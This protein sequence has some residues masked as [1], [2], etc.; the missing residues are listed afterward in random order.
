MYC[1]M[2]GCRTVFSW[3]TGRREYGAVHNPYALEYMR[4]HG[5]LG[6]DL[7]DIPCGGRPD[8]RELRA[9]IPEMKVRTE[10]S[11]FAHHC[12]MLMGHV[13]VEARRMTA[14][15][16]VVAENEQRS[17]ILFMRQRM[18]EDEYRR[19]LL[20]RMTDAEKKRELAMI[21][22]MLTDTL[23]DM[24]RQAV[25]AGSITEFVPQMRSLVEYANTHLLAI[26][27]RFGNCRVLCIFID[28]P[29]HPIEVVKVTARQMKGF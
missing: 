6:R 17:R 28:G 10:D 25:I 2:P 22:Q 29:N 4:Q 16:D 21:M 11:T 15:D 19:I 27:H 23:G 26:S 1:T 20:R 24:F 18:K 13:E 3:K 7:A 5:A 14:E 9:S 12:Y 8:Y